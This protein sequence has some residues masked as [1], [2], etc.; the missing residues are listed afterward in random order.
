MTMDV[1]TG[2]FRAKQRT[3][4][5]R[6]L[7]FS[8]STRVLLQ[9][10]LALVEERMDCIW[11]PQDKENGLADVTFVDVD[12]PQGRHYALLKQGSADVVMTLGRE[13]VSTH[14]FLPKPLR[15]VELIDNVAA[16]FG[17]VAEASRTDM[18]Y[19]GLTRFINEEEALRVRHAALVASVIGRF[20]PHYDELMKLTG[21]DDEQCLH[22]TY[23][24]MSL[25]CL[26]VLK[27]HQRGFNERVV[28]RGQQQ[29]EHQ[30]S[31]RREAQALLLRSA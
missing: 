7:Y 18:L 28:E 14:A 4:H 13:P 22:V 21:L 9:A 24:L 2:L 10:M 29:D 12:N 25:G 5:Y 17:V 8:S 30:E 1:F 19:L 6:C 3:R 11:V 16:M 27:P 20:Q 23:Y 31:E 15:H 26:R